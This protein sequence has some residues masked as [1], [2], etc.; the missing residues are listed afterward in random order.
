VK[1]TASEFVKAVVATVPDNHSAGA[2]NGT[3]IDTL[4]FSELLIVVNSGANGSSGT[5]DV[6]LQE[7]DNS[8]F[9][10]ATAITGAVFTQITEANDNTI[11][12]GRVNLNADRERYIRTVS[13]VGTAA[14][15]FGIVGIL[16]NAKDV[17][18]TQTNT[19]AFS[20]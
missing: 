12:V 17:P 19:V 6:I 16:L 15:D 11:Y 4:G 14:C 5:V 10:S 3:A 8:G 20:V 2:V 1:Y 9:S 13:T 18:V 7:D